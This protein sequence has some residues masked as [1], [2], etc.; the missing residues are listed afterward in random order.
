MLFGSEAS[1]KAMVMSKMDAIEKLMRE[2][3]ATIEFQGI[4]MFL[5]LQPTLDHELWNAFYG[6]VG[7]SD[8]P[9]LI[10][11]GFYAEATSPL[12]ALLELK[13]NIDLTTSIFS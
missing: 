2:M 12:E 7:E 1:L 13:S 5:H 9:G 11:A 3:P 6:R 10:P 4:N 8:E